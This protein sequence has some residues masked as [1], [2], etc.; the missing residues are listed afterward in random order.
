MDEVVLGG[1]GVLHLVDE[2]VA[3]LAAGG[4]CE[5]D[6]VVAGAFCVE[7]LA[8]GEGDFDEVALVA[9]SEDEFELGEGAPE[10]V[11]KRIGDGPLVIGIMR[12]GESEDVAESV[13]E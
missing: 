13:L 12:V 6:I 2:Q 3:E 10:D 5:V 11:Q 8:G 4:E 7:G 9:L 1:G